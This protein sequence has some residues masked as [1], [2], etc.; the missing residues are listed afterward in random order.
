MEPQ[1]AETKQNK[2]LHKL[3]TATLESSHLEFLLEKCSHMQTTQES[4]G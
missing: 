1:H 4:L 3:K 2:K